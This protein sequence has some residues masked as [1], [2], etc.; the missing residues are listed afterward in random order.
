MSISQFVSKFNAGARTNLFR[1][2]IPF[3]GRDLEFFCKG[4]S[5]PGHTI[6]KIPIYY[7]N[8]KFH[9]A[10]DMDFT[11]WT[12]TVIND[13]TFFIRDNIEQWSEIIKSKFATYGAT[14]IKE[15][16][17]DCVVYQ[18]DEREREV[19]GYRLYHAWPIEIS[20]IE[21]GYDT[22]NN[23]EEYTITF[24]YAYYQEDKNLLDSLKDGITDIKNNIRETSLNIVKDVAIGVGTGLVIGAATA[25]A[26]KLQ[27]F[28][29]KDKAN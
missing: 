7:Q 14:D 21:L 17:K 12:I 8:N 2:E 16:M 18:L 6:D 9:I 23:V 10:G 4:A 25:A 13:K 5:F 22:E 24:S 27:E 29:S 20:P 26:S 1:V 3:L 11:D 28:Y 19:R 15:Y